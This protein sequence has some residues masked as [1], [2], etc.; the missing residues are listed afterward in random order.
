MGKVKRFFSFS[1]VTISLTINSCSQVTNNNSAALA[2]FE[3]TTPCDDVSRSLLHIPSTDKCTMMKWALTLLTPTTYELIYTYGMDKAGT[4]GFSE[5]AITK[6]Q[7]GKWIKSK[8]KTTEIYTLT[9]DNVPSL[10]F[11]KLNENVL[12]LLD[13]N[14]NL[15]VGNGAWSYTLNRINPVKLSSNG[16]NSQ[17]VEETFFTDSMVFEGRLP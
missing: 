12:H 16:T 11:R 7:S 2:S 13:T 6:K 1:L 3:A 4:R 8:Y 5:G 10:S 14:K 9:A 15:M 17:K